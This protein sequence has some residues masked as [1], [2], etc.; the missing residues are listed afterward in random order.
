[1]RIV[2]KTWTER[3][4]T[5]VATYTLTACPDPECQKL[6]EKELQKRSEKIAALQN[7][8]LERKKAIARGRSMSKMKPTV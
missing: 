3:T 2:T 4:E 7:R 8:L 1:M 6:V 5:S